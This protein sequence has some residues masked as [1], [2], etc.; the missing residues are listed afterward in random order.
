M[1]DAQAGSPAL[2]YICRVEEENLEWMFALTK[3]NMQT[4]Y[5]QVWG[6]DDD[7]KLRELQHRDSR[8]FVID[9]EAFVHFR[10]EHDEDVYVLYVY[11]LQVEEVHRG[12]SLGRKL[13]R[14][15]EDLG[16]RLG[17][18]KVML[19]VFASN[20]GARRFY[21]RLG[22]ETDASSPELGTE[23]YLII[24]RSLR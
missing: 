5:E 19:T 11:E 4:M 8:F 2:R 10:F 20:A 23:G 9:R 7:D 16:R 13:M 21:G 17:C 22:Y 3:S 12:R 6:W 1:S 15:V 18:E 14:A 24:S